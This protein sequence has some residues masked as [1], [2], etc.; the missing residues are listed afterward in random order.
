[1]KRK[2]TLV[3]VA[4]LK[5]GVGKTTTVINF[6]AAL[7][8]AGRKVLV[9]DLD[10]QG[11]ATTGLG[12][13]RAD[14]GPSI[15]SVLKGLIPIEKAI[16]PT[17]LENVHLVSAH[18]ALLDF[19]KSHNSMIGREYLFEDWKE[20]PFLNE[21]DVVLFD[22][23]PDMDC[24]TLSS[25][26]ASDYY[27]VPVF[28]EIDPLVG[29]SDM[30]DQIKLVQ[31]RFNKLLALLGV[32]ITKYDKSEA[33][34]RKLE[35]RIREHQKNG[36]YTVFTTVIPASKRLSASKL[37]ATPVVSSDPTSNIAKAFI[38]LAGEIAPRLKPRLTGRSEKPVSFSSVEAKLREDIS[39]A[40][41]I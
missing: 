33:T 12:V 26:V 3:T 6:A 28:P 19:S 36:N 9:V 29:L 7:A 34:H 41:L 13:E 11:N 31:K 23:H 5:G 21:Y 10:F 22:T 30:F 25:L 17:K 8:E 32:L 4:N 35:Q 14:S 39:A 24:L 2:C 16:I 1:M 38:S 18:R 20:A 37:V 40:D 15:Y 27:L